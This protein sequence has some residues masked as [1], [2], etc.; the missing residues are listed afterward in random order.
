MNLPCRITVINKATV[1][2]LEAQPNKA[3]FLGLW[4]HTALVGTVTVSGFADDAGLLAPFV[5]PVATPAGVYR[6]PDQGAVNS[7][8]ALSVL[9]GSAT[10]QLR[11]AALWRSV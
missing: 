3:A 4:I 8:G 10:D 7:A 2:I 1:A 11:V 9:L 6:L 5:L